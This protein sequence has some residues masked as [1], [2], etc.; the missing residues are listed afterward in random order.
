MAGFSKI[1]CL[2]GLGGFMGAD[3]INPI[4]GQIL[5][6]DA[7]RQWLEPRY[8]DKKLKPIGKINIIVPE[9]PNDHNNWFNLREEAKPIFKQLIIFEA[10][11]KQVDLSKW[12]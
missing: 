5:I 3:G 12:V 6:G 2:G 7:D 9:S 11:L 10:E 8:F 4:G 1:Y